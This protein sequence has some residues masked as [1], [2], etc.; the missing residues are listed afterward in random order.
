M[1]IETEKR[2]Q[3]W[4]AEVVYVGE[5]VTSS[6]EHFRIQE[7]MY[8]WVLNNKLECGMYGWKFYFGNEKDLTFFLLRWS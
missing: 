1:K 5:N 3:G 2:E 4:V 8:T 7:E 6:Q